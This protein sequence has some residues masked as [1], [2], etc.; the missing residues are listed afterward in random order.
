MERKEIYFATWLRAF[1]AIMI[2]LCHLTTFSGSR[3]LAPLGQ[4][5]NIGVEI[6]IV[7]SG[8]LFGTGGGTTQ[9]ANS[10]VYPST[11]K[12]IFTI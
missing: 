3:V 10:M 7:L 4:F 12:D 1:A 2:L 5:F 6:F 11:K 8:F 9:I